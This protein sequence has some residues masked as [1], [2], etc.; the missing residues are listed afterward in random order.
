MDERA[1]RIVIENHTDATLFVRAWVQEEEDGKR[2][3]IEVSIREMPY[4]TE[5]PSDLSATIMVTPSI[6]ACYRGS[7]L[8]FS[9]NHHVDGG[10]ILQPPAKKEPTDDGHFAKVFR[11]LPVTN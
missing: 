6:Q 4:S 5:L 3:R 7:I 11:L 8:P 2:F 10:L 1:D 9:F